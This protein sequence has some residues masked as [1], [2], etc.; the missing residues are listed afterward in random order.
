MALLILL[1]RKKGQQ[2]AKLS[3]KLSPKPFPTLKLFFAPIA[4]HLCTPAAAI[5]SMTDRSVSVT[6][7]LTAGCFSAPV[8]C[9]QHY[10]TIRDRTLPGIAKDRDPTKTKLYPNIDCGYRQQQTTS[11]MGSNGP[12]R[13]R[14]Q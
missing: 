11:F 10:T 5:L 14:G 6:S 7:T 13:A 9:A 8:S 4:T 1:K 3:P 2:L 12:A